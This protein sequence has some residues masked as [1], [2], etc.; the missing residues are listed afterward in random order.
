MSGMQAP[1][2]TPANANTPRCNTPDCTSDHGRTP[3]DQSQMFGKVISYTGDARG[4]PSE[5]SVEIEFVKLPAGDKTVELEELSIQKTVELRGEDA[6]KA[7][8]DAGPWREGLPV[9]VTFVGGTD[10]VDKVSTWNG[11]VV[12]RKIV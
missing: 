11:V 8:H 1:H 2:S 10:K 9:A 5:E 3:D 4:P 7:R 12:P 6:R